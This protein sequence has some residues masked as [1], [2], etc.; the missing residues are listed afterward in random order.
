MQGSWPQRGAATADPRLKLVFVCI[1]LLI[2]IAVTAVATQ[3][4]YLALFMVLL[5]ASGRWRRRQVVRLLPLV[6]M[7]LLLWGTQALWYGSHPWYRFRLLGYYVTLYQEGMRHG[8]V[9]ALRVAAGGAAL[10]YLTVTTEMTALLAAA[11]WLRVPQPLLEIAGIAYRYIDVLG[12]EMSRIQQAQRM[13]LS[14]RDWR[15]RIRAAGLWV[16]TALLRAFDRSVAL[17]RSM[18]CRGYHGLLTVLPAETDTAGGWGGV[19]AA[20]GA[21]LLALGLALLFP[22][23]G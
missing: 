7:A 19:V 4:F 15:G 13:R 14:G 21:T 12:E 22:G 17:Y 9:L 2:I 16:G 10:L 6:G 11:R 20:A 23:S 1:S 18:V 5:V 8:L 3:L